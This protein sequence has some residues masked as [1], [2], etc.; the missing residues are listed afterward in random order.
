MLFRSPGFPAGI[1]GPELMTALREQAQRFGA[2]PVPND[3]VALRLSGDVKEVDVPDDTG[4][5]VITHRARSVILATGSA[6]RELGLANEKR[7]SGRGVSWCATCD[8]FFFR[9]QDIAVIGGG[10]SAVEEATFL[11]RFAR[12]VTLVHRRD[13]LRAS[14]IMQARALADPKLRL[15]WNQIGRA[16]V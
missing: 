4:R 10:D 2:E 1:Q 6:Y 9:D 3:V 14:K 5:G 7:L 13:Q 11:T 8:G 15:L 12:S 16:H